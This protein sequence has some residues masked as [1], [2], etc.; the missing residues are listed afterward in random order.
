MT[1]NKM[2]L[3]DDKMEALIISAPKISNSVPLP[4]SLTVGNLTVCFSQSAKYLG[5]T[6]DTVSY[7]HL[8]LPTTASV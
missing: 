6:L 4:D 7:T 5:V 3:N 8:T 2:K 1:H